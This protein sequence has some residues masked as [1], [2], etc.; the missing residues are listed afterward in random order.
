MILPTAVMGRVKE[1]GWFLEKELASVVPCKTCF[2]V[3]VFG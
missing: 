2:T 1:N 3:F